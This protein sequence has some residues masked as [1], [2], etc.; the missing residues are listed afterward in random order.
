[1][2]GPEPREIA[3]S[4]V[5][6]SMSLGTSM[7]VIRYAGRN[8][9]HAYGQNL[10]WQQ[11]N[12]YLMDNHR[13]AA[14]C[15]A[16]VVTPGEDYAIFHI[17]RHSDLLNL[18]EL[19]QIAPPIETLSIERYLAEDYQANPTLRSLL[20][21][22]DN[23]MPIFIRQRERH[24]KAFNY[25]WHNVGDKPWF[26]EKA[27]EKQAYD[28]PSNLAYWLDLGGPWIVNLDLDFFFAEGSGGG[29]FR[30]Y[31]DDYII[32]VAEALKEANAAGHIKC[33]TI[34]IS[35]EMCGGW[36]SGLRAL[37]VFSSAFGLA[38]PPL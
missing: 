8:H 2:K 33:L 16:Q 1:M 19:F 14:W 20:F 32:K 23:Y 21:R 11:G 22:W 4:L 37:D 25:V 29:I 15:W 28:L 30:M 17:D 27:C 36:D 7:H 35:P 12:V 31:S 18:N 5:A 9:S 10:L 3:F 6:V 34:A 38:L 24:L 13:A 26:K